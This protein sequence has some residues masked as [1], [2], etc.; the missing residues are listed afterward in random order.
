[1]TGSSFAGAC[2]LSAYP[3]SNN[4]FILRDVISS[5]LPSTSTSVGTS[6][7]RRSAAVVK[8]V[9]LLPA[10][11][12]STLTVNSMAELRGKKSVSGEA[13]LTIQSS[14]GMVNPGART[15]YP[16]STVTSLFPVLVIVAFQILLSP[17]WKKYSS[18]HPSMV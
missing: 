13:E 16:T 17:S 1:M 18:S 6:V 10:A 11:F 5:P 3:V 9:L 12:L 2:N 7:T 4:R 14:L 8:D 15:S